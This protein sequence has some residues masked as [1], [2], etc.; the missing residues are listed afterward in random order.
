VVWDNPPEVLYPPDIYSTEFA[1]ATSLVARVDG[2]AA[3]FLIGLTKFGDTKLPPIWQER[4]S[5]RVRLESQ[6]MAVLPAFRGRHIALL[7]KKIQAEEALAQGIDII[8]W[9]ADPL[10]FPNAVL[11]FTRLGAVAYEANPALYAFHNE[12]NQVTASR[13]SLTWLPGTRRVQAILSG[14]Q[15]SVVVDLA[16]QPEIVRVNDGSVAVCFDADAPTIAFEIPADWSVLQKVNLA[17]AQRW[18]E[19]TDQLF[20]HYLGSETGRY[21]ITGTG[22]DGDRRYLVGQRVDEKL[23]DSL[24]QTSQ[25]V[26]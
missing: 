25:P 23:L 8:N 5:H 26:S 15:P 13:F 17:A 21:I 18:R 19:T 24:C 7:F 9:T 16:G 6:V 20:V 22:V 10:Q 1:L 4:L 12:L 3:G 14:E 11:N 2:Q